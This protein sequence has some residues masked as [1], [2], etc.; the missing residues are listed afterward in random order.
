[1]PTLDE[2]EARLQTLLEVTL[3]KTLP[4]Y[5]AED[6]VF[7]HLAA[8][9]HNNLKEQEGDTYAPNVYVLI[10]HPAT[11]TRW[12]SEPRLVNELAEAL[13]TAGEEAGFHFLTDPSVTIAADTDLAADETH[14]IASYNNEN[15]SETRGMPTESQVETPVDSI[16]PD[17]FLILGG[18]KIIPLERSVINIGRRLDNQVVI[19]DPRVSR[20]HAQIRVIKSRFALFDLNST[21]GTYV[22]GQST[23]KSILSPGDV[24]S[25]AGVTLIFGQDL[26]SGQGKEKTT[27]VTRLTTSVDHPIAVMAQ[28]ENT[29]EK[30]AKKK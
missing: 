7:Q 3:L 13:H 17:A 8:A 11:L 10:A 25:L 18:T 23:S 20:T 9:M 14:I 22:N 29:N 5:K 26:P 28:T 2:L 6:R 4:G 24:I 12:H 16:P 1:M 21:G 27:T 19:D 30:K 15:V